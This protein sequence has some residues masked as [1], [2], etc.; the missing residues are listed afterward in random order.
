MFSCRRFFSLAK[1][2]VASSS[3]VSRSKNS[4]KYK[5][6]NGNPLPIQGIL[7]EHFLSL[8][9]DPDAI[10]DEFGSDAVIRIPLPG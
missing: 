2:E 5:Y 9:Q 3:L 1:V 10:D 8:G 7:R 6:L 4:I